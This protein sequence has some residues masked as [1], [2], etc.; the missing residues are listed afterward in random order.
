MIKNGRAGTL[1]GNIYMDGTST[2]TI[3]GCRIEGGRTVNKEKN[4]GNLYIGAS[5]A[6]VVMNSGSITGGKT[7]QNAGNVYIN[8]TFTMNGGTISGGVC[9][10]PTTGYRHAT[11]ATWNVFVV[12]GTLNMNGGFID[13][14]V[15][16]PASFTLWD[17]VIKCATTSGYGAGINATSSATVNIHGGVIEGGVSTKN[18]GGNIYTSKNV[19]INMT[20]GEISGG[21]GDV[22]NTTHKVFDG[23]NVYR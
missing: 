9:I 2:M 3:D 14:G 8:G 16:Y 4:G 21:Q 22:N 12:N 11:R 7:Y 5:K 15:A 23:D 19:T 1:G 20:G 6:T 10:D 13:G 18:Y 17:G